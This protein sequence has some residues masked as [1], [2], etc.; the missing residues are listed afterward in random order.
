MVR[1]ENKIDNCKEDVGCKGIFNNAKY[2][3]N[4]EELILQSKE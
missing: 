2:L 3:A 4:L 1:T